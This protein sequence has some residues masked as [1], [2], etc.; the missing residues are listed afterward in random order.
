MS[1]S[2]Y[3]H[4]FKNLTVKLSRSLDF[5]ENDFSFRLVA[6]FD[7]DNDRDEELEPNGSRA[8]CLGWWCTNSKDMVSGET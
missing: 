7:G 1:L 3:F 5:V 6:I 4:D 8:M 2:L